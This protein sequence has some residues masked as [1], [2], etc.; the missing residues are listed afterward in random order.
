MVEFNRTTLVIG[1]G[2]SVD[3]GFPTGNNLIQ[4]ISWLA[5][6][7]T[8]DT[9]SNMI[10]GRDFVHTLRS[11]AHQRFNL[12]SPGEVS[13]LAVR[14]RDGLWLSASIDNFLNEQQDP[15]VAQLG[16]F[17]IVSAILLHERYHFP[18]KDQ[19][20]EA[21]FHEPNLLW[22]SLAQDER[23]R[24]SGFAPLRTSWLVPFFRMIRGRGNI[25]DF[26]DRIRRLTLIIFNYD[27]SVEFFLHRALMTFDQLSPEDATALMNKVQIIHPYGVAAQLDFQDPFTGTS[28]GD[29]ESNSLFEVLRR[30]P[31]I[32]TFT[33]QSDGFSSDEAKEAIRNSKNLAFM[34]FGFLDQ[35]LK[36][37]GS[38]EDLSAGKDE[39]RRVYATTFGLSDY[40][41]M[42][43][44]EKIK[45]F[46][47]AGTNPSL[48]GY[49][50]DTNRIQALNGTAS[51]LINE[52][53]SEWF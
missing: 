51:D 32:Q 41:R 12:V 8:R 34:G 20:K 29:I 10:S 44:L 28:Y 3:F 40:Q 48:R 19:R 39:P 17:L 25:T 9:T 5:D 2:A 14:V 42:K 1:A 26:E 53:G 30:E 45:A 35:N 37:L 4:T 18:L 22:N 7:L 31:E 6:T 50:T 23:A 36:Y 16:K 11:A 38:N 43:C 27:R 47:W 15:N 49:Y 33:E 13:N 52:F 46:Q 21:L 24:G